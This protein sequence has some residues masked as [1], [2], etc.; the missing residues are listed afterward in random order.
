MSGKSR[1]Y[2]VISGLEVLNILRRRPVTVDCGPRTVGEGWLCKLTLT[3]PS[4][5]RT[6]GSLLPGNCRLE[7]KHRR[8]WS[9]QCATTCL[10]AGLILDKTNHPSFLSLYGVRAVAR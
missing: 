8:A 2:G 7:L 1:T 5:I 4:G 6:D 3:L 10:S 9:I